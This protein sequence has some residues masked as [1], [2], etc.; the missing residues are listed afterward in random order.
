MTDTLKATVVD[1]ALTREIPLFDKDPPFDL[2]LYRGFLKRDL[3]PWALLSYSKLKETNRT[4]NQL[5]SSQSV[6]AFRCSARPS[7]VESKN[8]KP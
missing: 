3:A 7:F 6:P 5:L 8:Q 2:L 1:Y 4:K